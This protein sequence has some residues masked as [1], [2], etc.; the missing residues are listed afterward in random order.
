MRSEHTGHDDA[1]QGGPRHAAVRKS[2]FSRY[3]LPAGKAAALASMPTAVLLGLTLT[4]KPAAAEDNPAIPFAPGPCVTAPD[5]APEEDPTPAP[6]D[7]AKPEPAPTA[8]TAPEADAP[9]AETP[10]P[11]ATETQA[12]PEAAAPAE[13]PAPEPTESKSV[14]DPLGIVPAITDL[15]D[16]P[17]EPA[18]DTTD[19][20]AADTTAE[21]PA[22]DTT[23]T[24]AAS[25]GTE[26]DIREA[27]AEAGAE[28]KELSEATKA[29]ATDPVDETGGAV[30]GEDGKPRFPCPEL[31]AEALANAK[32]ET[33]IPL[34]PDEAWTLNSSVLTL[35]GLKYHGIVEVKTYSG[36][37]K[38][39]L[40]FT[41]SNGVDIKDLHQTVTG[42][43]DKTSH[44]RTPKGTTSTI[45]NGTV[46][47]YTESLK[48]NLFGLIPVTF[49]PEAPPPLDV[50]LAIFTNVTVKQAGQFGGTLSLHM[51]QSI[52]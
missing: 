6:D 8:T 48:G 21:K 34:L 51:L 17:D 35:K 10:A 45:R 20:T 52:E 32:L 33:D 13:T 47:M 22:A 38:K 31:D 2:L 23:D 28:V 49:S 14:L 42:P 25:A 36:Q 5:A 39:V 40:K 12:E 44:V 27:A 3:R 16:G 1:V 41:A 43:G 7:T 29:T 30:T 50:P 24:A 19:T 9:A 15:L 18:A 37:V 4:P 26:T 46:T 11:E